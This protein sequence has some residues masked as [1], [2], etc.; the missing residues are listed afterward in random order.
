MKYSEFCDAF[1]PKDPQ[2]L[3]DLAARVPRNVNL[4]MS[5]Q[6]MFTKET[7]D[8]YRDCWMQHFS[9][10]KETEILR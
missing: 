4:T 5:Y 7:R 9:C 3:K 2:T 6:D 8:M 10:E 1:A